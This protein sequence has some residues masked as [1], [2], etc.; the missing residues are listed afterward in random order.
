MKIYLIVL[1]VCLA[2]Y[3]LLYCNF[4]SIFDLVFFGLH[5]QGV[6]MFHWENSACLT[7]HKMYQSYL[8]PWYSFLTKISNATRFPTDRIYWKE[9]RKSLY[10]NG[11]DDYIINIIQHVLKTPRKIFTKF[12]K[13]FHMRQAYRIF[14][15]FYY[16]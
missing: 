13:Y 1:E 3:L 16:E 10:I 11:L 14:R 7:K 4:L 2:V 8:F 15:Y 9:K 12:H 5:A 6:Q